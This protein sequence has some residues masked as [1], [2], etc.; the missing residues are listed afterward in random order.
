MF[1]SLNTLAYWLYLR[2][3]AA[4]QLSSLQARLS[5][6]QW[7]CDHLQRQ[8]DLLRQQL[9]SHR[10]SACGARLPETAPAPHELATV[11][12]RLTILALV[13]HDCAAE[14]LAHQPVGEIRELRAS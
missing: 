2:T 9:S 13:E 7:H 12:D 3:R 4:E 5:R 8:N 6:L 10:C 1:Q 11:T 14:D